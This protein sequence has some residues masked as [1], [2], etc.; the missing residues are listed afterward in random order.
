MAD[1]I[2]AMGFKDRIARSEDGEIRIIGGHEPCGMIAALGP[3]VDTK[4]LTT[5]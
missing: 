5:T 4:T 2:E 3:G 1:A